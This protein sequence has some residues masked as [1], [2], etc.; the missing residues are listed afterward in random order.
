MIPDKLERPISPH[1]MLKGNAFEELDKLCIVHQARVDA[2]DWTQCGVTETER[3]I[4]VILGVHT[5]PGLA[6]LRKYVLG[7][8]GLAYILYRFRDI[9]DPNDGRL[10]YRNG[11]YGELT[12]LLEGALN[13]LKNV[14]GMG[15]DTYY[16]TCLNEELMGVLTS[17]SSV[18]NQYVV[19][20]IKAASL[21]G[22]VTRWLW[23]PTELRVNLR[24]GIL[25]RMFHYGAQILNGETG[26]RALAFR[27]AVWT[28]SINGMVYEF[29]QPIKE[30]GYAR[31]MPTQAL[32]KTLDKLHDTLSE[33]M[34]MEAFE[35]MAVIPG[36]MATSTFARRLAAAK[37]RPTVKEKLGIAFDDDVD[38]FEPEMCIDVVY[39][40]MDTAAKINISSARLAQAIINDMIAE[41]MKMPRAP[42]G[43][44]IPDAYEA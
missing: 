33:N 41:I 2:I 16:V 42:G 5:A 15:R 17:Y 20:Q 8:I 4:T 18:K 37:A 29:S 21:D 25:K 7:E 34:L 9:I 22:R 26:H 44:V 36:S 12:V 39:Q 35:Q 13:K 24:G 40:L 11:R 28:P 3:G 1:Y 38:L 32:S 10:F 19:E 30:H 6:D 27:S 14:Y 43:E 31:H 23:K